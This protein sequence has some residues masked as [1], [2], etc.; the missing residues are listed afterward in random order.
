MDGEPTVTSDVA[1]RVGAVTA[2]DGDALSATDGVI[3]G[4]EGLEPSAASDLLAGVVD[5]SQDGIMAFR[6]RRDSRGQIVDFEWVVANPA[7]QRIV[8]RGSDELLGRG[9]LEVMPGNLESGLFD[10]YVAVV[11]TLTLQARLCER[12]PTTASRS[13][14]TTSEP[15]TPPSTSFD[16]SRSTS[17]RSIIRSRAT[18]PATPLITP[19]SAPSSVSLDRSAR[20]PSPKASRPA[21]SWTS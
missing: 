3:V 19:S 18:S 14:S 5:S 21:N 7:A 13:P 11:E 4:I 2:D 15:D 17:S 16:A 20:S 12:S 6:S 1:D 10:R 9:L 8:G